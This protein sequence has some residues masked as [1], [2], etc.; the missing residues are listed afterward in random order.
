M[1]IAKKAAPKVPRLV[2]GSVVVHRRRCGKPNCRCADGSALHESTV[3]SY[4]EGSKTRL[5]MLPPELVGPVRAAT[6]R[7]S[8]AK[9][10]LEAEA[11][12]GLAEL[13]ASLPVKAPRRS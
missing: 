4:S 8:E 10:R 11:N 12:A 2:R 6:R 7:Y 13:V 1:V 3:L 5:V 9:A